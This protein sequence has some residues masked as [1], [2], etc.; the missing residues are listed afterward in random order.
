M[1]ENIHVYTFVSGT[2]RLF[3]SL[4]FVQNRRR[5]RRI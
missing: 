5:R 3:K 2:D 1:V 4:S